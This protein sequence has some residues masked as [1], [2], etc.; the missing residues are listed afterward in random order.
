MSTNFTEKFAP[1]IVSVLGCHDRV[2]FKGHLPFGRDEHL[3]GWVDGCLQMHR[4]DFLPF[5]E[6]QSQTLVDHAKARAPRPAFPVSPSKAGPRR[7][8]SSRTSSANARSKRAW[9][10]CSRSWKPAVPSNSDM[11]RAGRAWSSRTGRSASFITISSIPNLASCT[12]AYRPGFPTPCRSTST[13]T[14][15]WPGKCC[16]RSSALSSTTMLLL[17]STSP[18]WPS[19]WPTAFPSCP[20]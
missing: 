2:I 16:T 20:G 12:F 8:N 5:V 9:S 19:A 3:N 10:P 6:K 13:G 1:S 7:R 15:G 17:N 4:M 11:V 14:N 18:S